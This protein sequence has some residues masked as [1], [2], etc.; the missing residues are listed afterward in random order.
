MSS[1]QATPEDYAFFDYLA[2]YCWPNQTRT[3]RRQYRLLVDQGYLHI[4]TM[5]ENALANASNGQYTRIAEAYRDF[6]DGSDAKKAVSQYRNN[7]RARE[8]RDPCW[9]NSIRITGL[10]RKRGLIR[11]MT[12][13]KYAERFFFWAI[14]Y[15]AYAGRSSIEINLD[16][17]RYAPG[18]ILGIPQGNLTFGACEVESFE[19]LASITHDQALR[20]YRQGLKN[21]PKTR[22]RNRTEYQRDLD[23]RRQWFEQLS[24]AKKREVL[25]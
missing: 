3:Q 17:Y 21:R 1:A 24:E 8:G 7:I 13:S 6:T 20:Q 16:S 25:A 11:A 22:R 10:D 5:L 4:E 23:T 19:R 9:T 2:D 15:E 12:W 18:P 14:P